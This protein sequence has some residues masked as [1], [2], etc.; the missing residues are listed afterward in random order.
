[1]IRLPVPL[2]LRISLALIIVT[3]IY[4]IVHFF[5]LDPSNHIASLR[6]HFLISYILIQA[7]FVLTGFLVYMMYKGQAWARVLWTTMFVISLLLTL[8]ITFDY[9]R[10][11]VILAVLGTIVS[12]L[13]NMTLVLLWHPATT[14]WFKV[15]KLPY[16]ADPEEKSTQSVN[17]AN[18]THAPVQEA[19]GSEIAGAN[20][21]AE[22]NLGRLI[23]TIRIIRSI[24]TLSV[25]FIIMNIVTFYGVVMAET[26]KPFM[27]QNRQTLFNMDMAINA[28][29]LILFFMSVGYVI[30]EY[31]FAR[32]KQVH[33]LDLL[34]QKYSKKIALV[35][36]FVH[37]FFLFSL[38]NLIVCFF[39][40]S[41]TIIYNY[42]NLI[43]LNLIAICLVYKI[44]IARINDA[45]TSRNFLVLSVMLALFMIVFS[46]IFER[47]FFHHGIDY[48]IE[49]AGFI[50]KILA[51]ILRLGE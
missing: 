7:F 47:F 8:R 43:F 28:T 34:T 11:P 46:G 22:I 2:Q 31:L 26:L 51:F 39:F 23:E 9:T 48:F 32:R 17:I 27:A 33:S 15:M 19:P 41:K 21:N 30:I 37:L 40:I 6:T 45:K 14:R 50:M 29:L 36:S 25:T 44:L 10:Y 20:A 16:V 35:L 38:N 5:T 13:G 49:P 4:D 42:I 18:H 24:Y 1:M 12:V 3:L